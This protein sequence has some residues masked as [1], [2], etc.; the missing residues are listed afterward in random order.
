MT[1]QAFPLSASAHPNL[2]DRHPQC[3]RAAVSDDHVRNL[4]V[5]NG[6][7]ADNNDIGIAQVLR[8][9][10]RVPLGV[11]TDVLLTVEDLTSVCRPPKCFVQEIRESLA[12]AVGERRRTSFGRPHNLLSRV[13]AQ[14]TYTR[15]TAYSR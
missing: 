9:P 5:E 1:G 7:V 8:P 10:G 15:S 13:H 2:G 14:Q 3:D 6:G 12:I 4:G 11:S